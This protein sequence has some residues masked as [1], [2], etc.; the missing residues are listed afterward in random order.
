MAKNCS[1][2]NTQIIGSMLAS[3]FDSGKA[4]TLGIRRATLSGLLPLDFQR[5]RKYG[6]ESASWPIDLSPD[7]PIAPSNSRFSGRWTRLDE[8]TLRPS[9]G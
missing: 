9:P 5:Q 7:V 6:K 8:L 4:E 2:W 3:D 1:N